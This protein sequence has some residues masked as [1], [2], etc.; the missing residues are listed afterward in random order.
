LAAAPKF[1]PSTIQRYAVLR[2]PLQHPTDPKPIAAHKWFVVLKNDDPV[3]FAIKTTTDTPGYYSIPRN[4]VGCLIYPAKSLPCFPMMTIVDPRRDNI[5]PIPYSVM[6]SATQVL[7]QMPTSFHA[8][9]VA[10]IGQHPLMSAPERSVIL[11]MIGAT[12]AAPPPGQSPRASS[13]RVS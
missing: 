6:K 1:N 4:R 13:P 10:A 12:S 8:E 3:L 7:G 11:G 5:H 2:A 9:L